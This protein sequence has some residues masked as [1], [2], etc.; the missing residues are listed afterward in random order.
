MPYDKIQDLPDSVREISPNT[1][2]RFTAPH[3]TAPGSSTRIQKIAGVIPR[4]KKQRTRLPGLLSSANMK[5][6]SSRAGGQKKCNRQPLTY[7]SD[8]SP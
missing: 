7:T 8:P 6:T 3:S 5:K 2:R 4:A 1:R